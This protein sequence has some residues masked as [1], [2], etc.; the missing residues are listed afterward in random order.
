MRPS[1]K[2]KYI[3]SALL[4]F[5]TV[6]LLAL[7]LPAQAQPF[8]TITGI[9]FHDFNTN[10]IRDVVVQSGVA[11]DIGVGNVTITAYDPAGVVRGMAV[12]CNGFTRQQGDQINPC[13]P[14]ERG[15]YIIILSGPGP[16]RLESTG[17]PVGF[18]PGIVGAG[19][20]TSVVF[21]PDPAGGNAVVDYAIHVP[22]ETCQNNPDL[23]TTCAANGDPLN[24]TIPN[25]PG[26]LPALVTWGYRA[27][28]G[29]GAVADTA[30]A[31]AS[32]IGSTW[33]VAVQRPAAPGAAGPRI[34]TAAYVKRHA[35]LG[36][37][38]V[39]G[40]Y[41]VDPTGP[42]VTNFVDVVTIGIAVSV[43]FASN[44]ARGL[45]ALDQPSIDVQ[46]FGAT[47]TVGLG[48]IEMSEDGRYLWLANLNDRVIYSIFVDNPP[49]T[50]TAADVRAWPAPF[51]D[52]NFCPN[53]VARPWGLKAYRGL[54]YVGV[55]C[56]AEFDG[57]TA[58]LGMYVY[59]LDPNSGIYN[60][61]LNLPVIL[62]Y[63]RGFVWNQMPTIGNWQTWNNIYSD[64][65]YNIG[66]FNGLARP[67]PIVSDI[68]F[69]AEGNMII[70]FMDR[71]G[72]QIGWRNYRPT[73][74]P[75]GTD[76]TTL[77]NPYPGG[78]I[79]KAC[80]NSQGGWTVESNGSCGGVAGTGVGNNQG[81]GGGEFFSFDRYPDVG[82]QAHQETTFGSL[83]QMPGAPEVVLTAEDP[84]A[85]LDA[86]GVNYF[87]TA[88][89]AK[90]GG[91]ELYFAPGT[92]TG[93]F[94]KANGLGDLEVLCSVVPD[95]E[96]GNRV[97]LDSNPNGIQDPDETPIA[98][99]NVNIYDCQGNL[100]GTAI[101]DAQ[102]R[103]GFTSAA[104]P[105][106][107]WVV[108]VPGLVALTCYQIR[109]DDPADYAPGGPLENL[110]ATLVLGDTPATGMRDSDG[111]V[112][113]PAQLAGVG[114][115]FPFR[116][117]NTQD[118]GWNNHTYDFGFNTVPPPRAT[119]TPGS[120]QAAPGLNPTITKVVDPPFA[121]P[122]DR[123]TWRVTVSNPHNVPLPNVNFTDNMDS[124]LEIISTSASAGTVTV[125]GQTVTWSIGVLDPGQ[126]VTTT[127]VTRIRS[128]TALPFTINNLAVLGGGGS[129]AAGLG[130]YSGQASATLLSVGSLP[131]TGLE[132]WWRTPLLVIAAGLALGLVS[133]LWRRSKTA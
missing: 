36:P 112:N 104:V 88:T 66:P 100:L 122:G 45:G 58:D 29:T 47:G 126:S 60:F 117:I 41:L 97:W 93:F 43:N 33:G 63:Q 71:T 98:G 121:Q 109:L 21:V 10:G 51:S 99:V 8:G 44:A 119:P 16:Y 123:V 94:G 76:P 53:G 56:T 90:F 96:I 6:L 116:L 75:I 48:D 83:T 79:L 50:P 82:F 130:S 103:Y 92:G 35:G 22:G 13:T 26:P 106:Q 102:G 87:T 17:L 42:T 111:N 95:I 46:A 2:W 64:A 73:V 125:S 19:S 23:V 49:R 25:N 3:P 20:D 37:L 5:V 107:P 86:G 124:R 72:N 105:G 110:Y 69:D 11:F 39:G 113:D 14:A 1:Q 27:A 68:E 91:D 80:R 118:W 28:P 67:Q 89:G 38:G 77:V 61:V 24:P 84:A 108:S 9:V 115:N 32:Q 70:A 12:S 54:I 65:R 4:L 40:I 52:D 81:V 131:A 59:A 31:I 15:Q 129:A 127:I 18:Q 101:T 34:F 120:G 114:G 7:V 78:E 132:P 57:T 133:L 62:N 55:V 128:G 74:P 85:N 30:L